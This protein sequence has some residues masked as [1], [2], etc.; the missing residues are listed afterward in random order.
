MKQIGIIGAGIM[1]SGMAQNFL[2]QG[3]PVR[4]WNRSPERLDPLV[5]KGA[6]VCETPK[7]LTAA[8]DIIIECVADDEGSREVW[9]SEHG[10]L[11]GATKDKVLIT[12]ATL[13]LAW[14]DALAGM[15]TQRDLSFLDM[16]LTGGRAGAENGGLSLLVGGDAQVLDGIR[17]ELGAISVNI[18]HFGPVGSG[19]RFKLML[20]TLSAIHMNA[21]AQAAE[22]ARRAG[23]DPDV[24]YTALFDGKMGPASPA[25]GILVRDKDMPPENVN[26]AIKWIEK[27][28]RYAQAMAKAYGFN[29]DLLNA[30]HDDYDRAKQDGM[31]ERDWSAIAAAYK[32]DR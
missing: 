9:S 27:D 1:A 20:N 3:Y 2:K 25:T 32:A 23:I 28:L 21:A 29:F 15:C 16:P 8:S 30:T 11:A 26:F 31:A 24:F 12:A 19:M 22:L 7:E 10:I 14:V 18:F 4:V 6:Q 5:D 17:S 13:S